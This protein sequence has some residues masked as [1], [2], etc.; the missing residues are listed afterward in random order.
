MIDFEGFMDALRNFSDHPDDAEAE[1]RLNEAKGELVIRSYIP[2]S[3]KE[4]I[5]KS[6]LAHTITSE[7]LYSVSPYVA[8][9]IGETIFGLMAYAGLQVSDPWRDYMEDADLIW[10]TGVGDYIQSMCDF[11]F[12]KLQRMVDNSLNFYNLDNLIKS[13]NAIDTTNVGK[14]VGQLSDF[15][16]KIGDENYKDVMHDM[17]TILGNTDEFTNGVRAGIDDSILNALKNI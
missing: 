2:I 10:L 8:V 12:K 13:I 5:V 6:I 15:T 11:D 9:E 4:E 1:K 3:E 7:D 14:L 16:D 17:A